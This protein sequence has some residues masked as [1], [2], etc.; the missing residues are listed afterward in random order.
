MIEWSLEDIEQAVVEGIYKHFIF[1]RKQTMST[2][3]RSL[4]TAKELYMIEVLHKMATDQLLSIDRYEQ[5]FIHDIQ[6]MVWE[7]QSIR[8]T[9]SLTYYQREFLV[10]LFERFA[11]NR[12]R[13][14]AAYLGQIN[15]YN[16]PSIESIESLRRRIR[17]L[18]QNI[19]CVG[20]DNE[21]LFSR[22]SR[23]EKQFDKI[24]EALKIRVAQEDEE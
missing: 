14:H 18:E 17:Y 9:P 2:N 4:M 5:N 11:N 23:L 15:C 6:Q 3:P 13:D 19:G 21:E 7:R 8:E 10:R 22:I 12:A 1:G 20:K 24:I 16:S